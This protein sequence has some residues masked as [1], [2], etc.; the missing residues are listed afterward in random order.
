M[1]A[2]ALGPEA[3][4]NHERRVREGFIKK[5]L[6]GNAVLD[7]GYRGGETEAV[8]ITEKAIGVELDYPGYDG[9]KLPFEDDSQDAVFASHTLEHIEDY[10]TALAEWY[11]VVKPSGFLVIAVPHQH[12]YERKA[13]PP[14]RFNADHRRFYTSRSLLAE[15]EESLPLAG[16]RV[17]SLR[18]L[19]DGF[20]Y[21]T[22]PQLH[23]EGSYEIELVLEKLPVPAYVEALQ[24]P[25]VAEQT[26][27][28]YTSMILHALQAGKSGRDSKAQ[29]IQ[30]ILKGVPLPPF[31]KLERALQHALR[32]DPAIGAFTQ[33]ELKE[34]LRP[35]VQAAAFDEAFYTNFYEDIG[36]FVKKGLLASGRAHFLSDGYFEGRFPAPL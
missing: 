21:L 23:A 15:V 10:R 6:S 11:R 5:Y 17:R 25:V 18:E 35:I 1:A 22:P 26:L 14:S 9:V 3:A 13:E 29:E 19:D 30:N 36:D 2:R 16:Y 32:C 20:N 8:P 24:P 27:E 33:D 34:I 4:R 12:L 7:I 28:F 31:A